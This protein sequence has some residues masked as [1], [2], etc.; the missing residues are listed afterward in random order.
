MPY[1]IKDIR[2]D[3]YTYLAKHSLID[4][5]HKAESLLANDLSHP[6]LHFKKI[7]L[8]GTAFYS[9][10]LDKKYRGICAVHGN[11]IEVIVITAHYQ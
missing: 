1:I 8:K 10:R 5:W 3:L 6:S 11:I 9:F 2:P 4:K 7:V